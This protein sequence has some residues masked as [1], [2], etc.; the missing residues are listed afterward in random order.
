MQ[1][2]VYPDDIKRHSF[3]RLAKAFQ[4]K[5]PGNQSIQLS[6]AQEVLAR[7]LGYLSY[8][9][10]MKEAEKPPIHPVVP[11]LAVIQL[12][13]S[14]V[15]Q[16]ELNH[17]DV[18]PSAI[19][20][21]VSDLPFYVLSAYSNPTQLTRAP[22]SKVRTKKIILSS[23]QLEILVKH[24]KSQGSLRDNALMDFVV[25]G[26]RSHVF[27]KLQKKHL[28]LTP[29]SLTVETNDFTWTLPVPS[30]IALLASQ[31]GAD[32]EKF[33]FPSKNSESSPMSSNE[34]NKLY[35]TWLKGCYLDS[36][37]TSHSARLAIVKSAIA[38]KTLDPNNI[39]RLMRHAL[40]PM[41]LAIYKSLGIKDA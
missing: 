23:R 17:E 27:L 13:L 29:S 1:I 16:A 32:P 4:K 31:H 18:P 39:K 12:R 26:A 28:T 8:H 2:P 3:K 21:F 24:V 34:F 22:A 37:I 41:T 36:Y 11:N 20:S 38:D 9:N 33:L 19:S 40:P 15:A 5:W 35:K 25:T 30:A 14:E 6:L 7:G 10:L